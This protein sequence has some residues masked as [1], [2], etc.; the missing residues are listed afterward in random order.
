MTLDAS[1]DSDLQKDSGIQQSFWAEFWAEYVRRMVHPVTIVA[2]VSSSIFF[3]FIGPY[4]T[5]NSETLLF[6]LSFWSGVVVS[7]CVLAVFFGVWANIKFQHKPFWYHSA[8][9]GSLFSIVYFFLMW[10]TL[11]YL[12]T[13]QG[14]P[15]PVE[16]FVVIVSIS[17]L[18]YVCMWFFSAMVDK[19]ASEISG[20]HD[21]PPAPA[22]AQGVLPKTR[23]VALHRVLKEFRI[24]LLDPINVVFC[25][26]SALLFAFVALFGTFEDDS[27]AMRF[28]SWS[29][30]VWTTS[31]ITLLFAVWANLRY[32]TRPFWFHSNIGSTVFSV[33]YLSLIWIALRAIFPPTSAPSYAGFYAGTVGVASIVYVGLWYFAYLIEEHILHRQQTEVMSPPIAAPFVPF[34]HT[35]IE[36][37]CPIDAFLQRLGPD[38]GTRLIRLAMSDHYIEAYTDSGMHLLYMRFADAMAELTSVKGTQVHRSHWVKLDEIEAVQKDGS[39][40]ALL[41]SDGG[42]VPISRSRKKELQVQGVI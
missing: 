37:P 24:R 18:V 39:K 40:I 7:S 41:M 33:I 21:L 20:I 13:D 4:N 22:N 23:K 35:Q 29:L 42:T 1:S 28:A 11:N 19:R 2:C 3:A 32:A 12:F 34:A 8:I 9:G 17:A 25:V 5:Y 10:R 36:E 14:I 38:A 6:R 27:F 30:L 26:F 16:L 15:H 31:F